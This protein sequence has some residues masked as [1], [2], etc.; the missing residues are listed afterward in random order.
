MNN[1]TLCL[2]SILLVS[3]ILVE[4]AESENVIGILPDVVTQT[5][6]ATPIVT[7]TQNQPMIPIIMSTDK[8]SIIS[9][10]ST[11]VTFDVWE[12]CPDGMVCT[13][14]IRP[15]SNVYIQLTGATTGG[16]YTD[17]NG[18]VV[19]TI[20]ANTGIVTATASK[21]G[22]IGT[23]TTITVSTPDTPTPP[24]ITPPT[25]E[26]IISVTFV[27]DK[28]SYVGEDLVYLTMKND[29]DQSVV[30]SDTNH[31]NWW[32]ETVSREVY[33]SSSVTGTAESGSM[34]TTADASANDMT[35]AVSTSASTTSSTQLLPGD[36]ITLPWDKRD[37]RRVLLQ[38]GRYRGCVT[39]S[40]DSQLYK[41]CTQPFD[42][43]TLDPNTPTPTPTLP[44]LDTPTPKPKDTFRTGPTVS[45]RPV[46]D[47]I[48]KSE[49][50]LIE[51]YMDNPS[52][53]DVVMYADVRISVPSGIGIYGQGFGD[54]GSAGVLHGTFDIPPGKSRT[55][56]MLVKGEKTGEFL[57]KFGGLY[58]PGEDKDAFQPISLTHNFKVRDLA[59]PTVVATPKI[60]NEEGFNI[61]KWLSELFEKIFGSLE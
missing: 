61:I 50:G 5:V 29:G 7:V 54:T 46:K 55:I 47:D 42:I 31:V 8:S 39:W 14:D 3:M 56:Q 16:I 28:S 21:S 2:L 57:I 15:I 24:P 40:H 22:Y 60:V 13:M 49:D 9:G 19:T 44:I 11:E 33:S 53:N 6:T 37:R 10:V 26:P 25:P 36:S 32:I 20:N 23:S 27:A 43:S 52:V 59:V 17:G 38:Q 12:G 18:R 41:S 35:N 58:W 30:L 4:P 1:K 51:L 34:A 48:S 45:L